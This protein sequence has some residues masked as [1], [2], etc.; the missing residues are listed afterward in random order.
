[1]KSTVAGLAAAA[2]L[3]LLAPPLPADAQQLAKA[4]SNRHSKSQALPLRG[5]YLWEAFEQGSLDLGYVE[6]RS[7]AIERR[8]AEGEVG[9]PAPPPPLRPSSCA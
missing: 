9:E 6:G 5:L 2:A 3:I 1:M 8:F 4:F 7:I